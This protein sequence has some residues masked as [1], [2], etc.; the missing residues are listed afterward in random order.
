MSGRGKEILQQASVLP[1]VVE[2]R[3]RGVV[4]RV[5]F[6]NPDSGWSVLRLRPHGRYGEPCTVVAHQVQVFAGATMEFMGAW[7]EHPRFGRQFK[8]RQATELRPA[9][10]AALEKYLG[11]GL[12]RGVGPK[13]AGRIVRHFGDETL[14]VFEG[15]IDRLT[16]VPG[17][18][19]RKLASIRE[20]WREHRAIRDVML[21]L[22]GHG[23]ST[24]FAVRIY[25]QY[26][27]QAIA[28][29]TENPY[30]L[31]LDFFGIGFFTADRIARSLGHAEDSPTRLGAA[32]RHVLSAA[33][34]QGHCYLT[35]P[36][37]GEQVHELLGLD[38]APRLA[39][40][41]HDMETQQLLRVLRL[42]DAAGGA[43][44]VWYFSR[45]LYLDEEY[46]G[47]RL[48]GLLGPC[49]LDS[50]RARDWL[51]RYGARHRVLL[52]E[53]Q[54]AAVLDLAG[55]RMGVLTGGPGCGKTTT[56]RVL[57][58]LAQAM[59]R[60]VQLAAPT[61]RA[62]QRMTE[63]IGVEA[64]TIHRM[65]E[66]QGGRFARDES[67]PLEADMLIVDECSMLDVPL[68]A[69]L[70]RALPPES[71]LVLIGDA[72]QLPSVGP[73]NILHDLIASGLV[74][75][76]RLTKIFR[77]ASLSSIIRHA[78]EINE[79]VL[80]L[81][82][83]PFKRPEL[84][85]DGSD[86][87]FFD[88]E[89]ATCEQLDFIARVKR[90]YGSITLREEHA[91]CED[92]C[93]F[94]TAESPGGGFALPERFEHVRLDRLVS[95]EGRA[96]ELLAVM[97]RVH[98]WSALYYGLTAVDVVRKLYQE[99]IPKYHHDI[100]EIQVLTPMHRG[101]LGAANLNRMIQQAVN[102]P[103]AGRAE[104]LVGERVFRAGDRVIHRRNNYELGVFNGDIGSIVRVDND[105]LTLA[106]AF[107][108]DGR[109]VEYQR[110]SITELDLA[111]AITIHKAQGS[112]F[113]AV[114]LP[115]LTQHYRMLCRNLVYTGLTRAKKLAVFVGTRRALAMAVAN[116]EPIRRQ[117]ALQHFLAV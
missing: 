113:D 112:E 70:L 114:I 68:T 6:H 31:A 39:D 50:G 61:G 80:P 90:H 25:K 54:A 24:L 16:E 58:A 30:R 102:P 51:D 76:A 42:P 4:E 101:S 89:E 95:A 26:G 86:C 60:R 110:E 78:H 45:S 20:A 7:T 53:E 21:F 8:A 43:P 59:G 105:A 29:V 111:Y 106:V 94:D 84:W 37:I 69:S 62:A 47:A 36:Q 104:I 49:P 33:R 32:I 72:D 13:I 9:T 93:R 35:A 88:A 46:I 48:R 100:K 96:D 14:Q 67:R 99:W 85:R 15:E 79:G 11:S 75:V 63:V 115:V 19:D 44:Q 12:I 117:T 5:S 92:L 27:D 41:L 103:A 38:L 82:E 22:Q 87:L 74:P 109:E 64:R 40:L 1:G 97:R 65:L 55:R 73:G 3:L 116:A 108:P 66:Y 52:S 81:M 23:V 91:A 83:S 2:E 98:P 56:T 18:A 107:S 10:A 57:V 28:L 71:Q 17:I 34:E 77:Q